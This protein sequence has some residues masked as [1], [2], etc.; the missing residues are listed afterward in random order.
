MHNCFITRLIL[1]ISSCRARIYAVHTRHLL[2][3]SSRFGVRFATW[4]HI[5][6]VCL[7]VGRS[8]LLSFLPPFSIAVSP[9]NREPIVRCNSNDSNQ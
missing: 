4:F 2:A 9:F 6:P 8:F 5:T 1:Y 7:S 3:G